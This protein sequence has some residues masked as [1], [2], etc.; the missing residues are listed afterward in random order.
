MTFAEYDE[1]FQTMPQKRIN[2]QFSDGTFLTNDKIVSESL[3]LEETLCSDMNLKYGGCEAS[4][5]RIRVANNQSYKDLWV[6]VIILVEDDAGV[7]V[8]DDNDDYITAENNYYAYSQYTTVKLGRYKVF[9]D[10]PTNDRVYRDLVCYDVMYDIINT[11]IASWYSGLTFPITL[12]NFR[13]SLF[14]Y[15]GVTQESKTLINDN[16]SIKGGYV[17]TELSCR[18]IIT[19]ICELNGVFGHINSNNKFDYIS[20]PSSDTI[21]LAH[22]QNGSGAYEDYVTK[23]ITGIVSYSA[24][25]NIGKQVG[26]TTNLYTIE[27]N[28]LMYGNEGTTAQENALN[29]LLNKIKNFTYRPYSVRTYGNPV[30][31]LGTGIIINTT[32]K[33]ISSFVM[34]RY[35]KGIQG[36]LDTYGS[37]GDEKYPV[38]VNQVKT[39]IKRTDGKVTKITKD[40]DKIETSVG[41]WQ[42]GQSISSTITQ[43]SDEVVLKVDANG[44]IVKVKLN[45][46]PSGSAFSISADNISFISNGKIQLTSSSLEINSTKFKV[47]SAGAVT[48]SDMT[49]TGGSLNINNVFKVATDG[50]ITSTGGTIGGWS[51]GENSLSNANSSG[52][53]VSLGNGTNANQDVLV[54]RTGPSGS[55]VYPFYVRADGTLVATKATITGT[56]TTSSGNIGG[57]TIDTSKLYNG[58]TSLGDTSHDG[59]YVGTDGIALGKGKFK[60]TNAGALTATSGNIGALGITSSGLAITTGTDRMGLY[61]TGCGFDTYSGTTQQ[62]STSI[63]SGAITLYRSVGGE[64]TTYL[65]ANL[66]STTGTKSRVVNTKDYSAKKL[67]CYETPTPMFG[68]I[69]EGV[70]AEDGKCYIWIDSV[71]AQTINTN[72][73]QVFLQK[74]GQGECY[75]AERKG[76]YFVVEGNPG[77]SFG[78]E[79]KAKQDGFEMLR[80]DTFDL[81]EYQSI[82]YG[83]GALEHIS[84]IQ[85]ERE[86]A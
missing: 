63:I 69:G 24:D 57:F 76:S 9:S 71:F 41:D 55:Y 49:I 36:M 77:L 32:N 23:K 19:N 44:K 67:Y 61:S 35:L 79:I 46:T 2:L 31:K 86:V 82:N 26:T 39:F 66:I 3:E 6:D 60:V 43:L 8:S 52:N 34:H 53:F 14:N 15:L 74:Y 20:L 70:I 7:Y 81:W 29:A 80:L 25:G 22:Y 65:A 85:N 37:Y 28:L 84:D 21:T 12:K 58:M 45:A 30:I 54:V 59:V 68:D 75:V 42:G 33:V 56:I 62:Y 48:C 83:D 78:W 10:K 47:T 4:E 64:K 38:E 17:A 40:V 5:F 13:N 51:I 1:L 50:K 11:D 27:N 18:D 16:Y 73:Y 72:G